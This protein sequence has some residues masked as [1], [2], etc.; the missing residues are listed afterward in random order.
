M[1][2][3]DLMRTNVLTVSPK[4]SLKKINETLHH[5]QSDYI[6]IADGKKLIGMLTY[7]DLFR[8]LLPSYK[9]VMEDESYWLNPESMESRVDLL[10]NRPVEEIMQTELITVQKSLPAVNAGA[11]MIAKKIKQIP[12]VENNELVGVISFRDITWGFLLKSKD[13]D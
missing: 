9:E 6:I 8:H 4:T 3:A 5:F 10:K 7:S 11:L 12:V 2:V 13:T 1:K